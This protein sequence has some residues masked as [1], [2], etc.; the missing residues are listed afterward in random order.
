MMRCQNSS[1]KLLRWEKKCKENLSRTPRP[2][3]CSGQ[4]QESPPERG[5]T[6]TARQNSKEKTSYCRELSQQSSMKTLQNLLPRNPST[7]S[8]HGQERVPLFQS[9]RTL[10]N[11][12]VLQ[13]H[14]SG[15]GRWTRWVSRCSSA[16]LQAEQSFSCRHR[17]ES[18]CANKTAPHML[19][20]PQGKYKHTGTPTGLLIKI[21]ASHLLCGYDFIFCS[22]L[23]CDGYEFIHG[24]SLPGQKS[25][26]EHSTSHS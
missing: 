15:A 8:L 22:L 7:V 18:S 26:F 12:P 5:V 14:P 19:F 16:F 17:V 3:G 6:N 24:S 2:G 23:T 11:S 4:S 20:T 1:R 25:G 21:T 10:Q 9:E 13:E